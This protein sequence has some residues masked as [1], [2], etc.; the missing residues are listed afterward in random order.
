MEYA[1]EGLDPAPRFFAVKKAQGSVHVISSDGLKEDWGLSYTVGSSVVI[2]APNFK[3]SRSSSESL[4][5]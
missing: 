5:L 2:E 4:H 1:M 3:H